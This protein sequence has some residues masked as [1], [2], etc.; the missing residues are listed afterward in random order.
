MCTGNM[1]TLPHTHSHSSTHT[2][3][4]GCKYQDLLSVFCS[5]SQTHTHR[6]LFTM[7][8]SCSRERTSVAARPCWDWGCHANP[9]PTH[10]RTYS[11]P[12]SYKTASIHVLPDTHK[13]AL[14][15]R[16]CLAAM[17]F[18]MLLFSLA[19]HFLHLHCGLQ[20]TLCCQNNEQLR[21]YTSSVSLIFTLSWIFQVSFYPCF[22]FF[23]ISYC[24]TY[25]CQSSSLLPLLKECVD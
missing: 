7:V 10:T 25:C 16:C 15:K 19:L 9:T 3:T 20:K 18:I 5:H 14:T 23:G 13:H 8:M 2:H 22:F 17:Q 21:A 12:R 1:Q 4:R 11:P 24:D 6:H